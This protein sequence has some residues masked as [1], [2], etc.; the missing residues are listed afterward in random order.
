MDG[1]TTEGNFGGIEDILLSEV[2]KA[3][4]GIEG[5]LMRFGQKLQ[6]DLIKSLDTKRINASGDLRQSIQAVPNVQVSDGIFTYK[7][8]MLEYYEDI[9]EGTKGSSLS[10]KDLYPIMLNWVRTKKAFGGLAK[11]SE[12]GLKSFA[13]NTAGKVSKFGIKAN[14]FFSDVINDGRFNKLQNDLADMGVSGFILNTK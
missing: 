6:D 10:Q 13:W 7:L 11:I 9:D 3:G 2:P 1:I 14:N 12:N 5:L 4:G 8:T